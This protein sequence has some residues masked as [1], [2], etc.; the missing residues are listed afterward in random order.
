MEMITYLPK[1]QKFNG[2]EQLGNLKS[3]YVINIS[4]LKR[5]GIVSLG[6]T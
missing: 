2:K 5:L 1:D 3:F 6:R 4:L